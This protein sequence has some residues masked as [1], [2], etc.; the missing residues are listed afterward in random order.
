M[1]AANYVAIPCFVCC[2]IIDV[3]IVL[4]WLM[5]RAIRSN[6]QLVALNWFF[7]EKAAD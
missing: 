1:N 6:V 5:R 7:F 4:L 3:L 2:C